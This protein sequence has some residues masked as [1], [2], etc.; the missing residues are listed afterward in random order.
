[1]VQ[2]RMPGRQLRDTKRD[3]HC[4]VA[5][6]QQH[7]LYLCHCRPLPMRPVWL[8]VNLHLKA[9]C[10]RFVVLQCALWAL[11]VV[12]AVQHKTVAHRRPCAALH[13]TVLQWQICSADCLHAVGAHAGLSSLHA[14]RCLH[15]SAA[16]CAQPCCCP[17]HLHGRWLCCWS[18]QCAPACAQR[19]AAGC[20]AARWRC[21]CQGRCSCRQFGCAHTALGWCSRHGGLRSTPPTKKQCVLHSQPSLPPR[22]CINSLPQHTQGA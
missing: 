12:F 10:E 4:P 22:T 5:V 20:S 18:P 13:G 15:E 21:A 6:M 2:S 11:V 8:C 9:L 14:L 16:Q 7:P 1:M 17:G 19:H 3:T